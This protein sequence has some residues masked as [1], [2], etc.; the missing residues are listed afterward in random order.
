MGVI[1]TGLGE[2]GDARGT[3]QNEVEEYHVLLLAENCACTVR[4]PVA[5]DVIRFLVEHLYA[6]PLT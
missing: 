1:A 5:E 4:G 6:T 3:A 2:A